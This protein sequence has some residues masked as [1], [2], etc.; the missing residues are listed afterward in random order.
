MSFVQFLLILMARKWTI[1]ITFV[2]VTAAALAL[3]L[4]LPKEYA[5]VASVV[6]DVKPM[7]PIAGVV[8]P[9]ATQSMMA[10]QIDVLTSQR[11][12]LK[13]VKALGLE[14]SAIAREN[15]L[16]DTGGQGA[17][18][19]WLAKLLLKNLEVRPS[20]ESTVIDIRYMGSDPKFAAGVANAFAKA[21]I[22]TN[23]EMKIEPARQYATWFDARSRELRENL[24]SARQR[25]SDFQRKSGI[26][27]TDE[28]L[29]IESAR[30]HE[31]SS[32]I[33][34]LQTSSADSQSRQKS[35]RSAPPETLPEVL[36]HPLVQT[37]KGEVA[38]AQA[39][40][41]V[42][43]AQLGP[44]H[45]QL[46]NAVAE[47]GSLRAK[48]DTEIGK[49]V[50]GIST[51]YNSTVQRESEIRGQL[52]QQRVKVMAL[53]RQRDEAQVLE[54]EV[55]NAQK[56]F[57]AATQRQ[58]QMTLESQTNQTN[59]F[60]LNPAVEPNHHSRPRVLLNT[61]VGIVLGLMLGIGLACV[62]E[63]YDRRVRSQGD[64]ED[65]FDVP[66]L[67]HIRRDRHARRSRFSALPALGR[68]GGPAPA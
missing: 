66:L 32:Q 65:V 36:Q 56:A 31:L 44:N 51:S 38:R 12:A 41:D 4:L 50:H 59:I 60:L 8:L 30:L 40:L 35:S 1:A 53:K 52:N 48:L 39:K 26:I 14:Q 68:N 33:V 29:D 9:T 57:E 15:F 43:N 46:G 11:V 28:R 18:D 45:P 5:A 34:S 61:A 62:R 19:V 10:T 13:V 20:R 22:E 6:V 27:A 2:L 63:L 58:T 3:S 23:L 55:E 25:L 21:Y 37:L 64:A 24:E 16:D 54:Q 47:L 7:D 67:A 49:V 42:M 17:L